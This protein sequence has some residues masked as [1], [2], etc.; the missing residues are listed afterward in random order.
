M[1]AYIGATLRM[2]NCLSKYELS[3]QQSGFFM[4]YFMKCC[5]MSV[6]VN[7]TL[8]SFYRN[9]N[10]CHICVMDIQGCDSEL[11]FFSKNLLFRLHNSFSANSVLLKVEQ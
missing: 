9:C 11:V 10:K 8:L 5:H 7:E 1:E 4:M 6:S 3:M 2:Q